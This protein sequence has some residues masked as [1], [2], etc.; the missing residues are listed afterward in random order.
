MGRRHRPMAQFSLKTP[1]PNQA[2]EDANG[3]ASEPFSVNAFPEFG[4]SINLPRVLD[5]GK[6]GEK[7]LRGIP[8]HRG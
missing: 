8:V 1:P 7:M 3:G 4:A 2:G 5:R 6:T